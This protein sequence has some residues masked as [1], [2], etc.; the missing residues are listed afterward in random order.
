MD[1]VIN[2]QWGNGLNRRIKEYLE[3]NFIV[4][5]III[6]IIFEYLLFR[7]YVYRE[8]INKIPRNADQL[9][10]M[11][12]S[13]SI[14]ENIILRNWGA[15]LEVIN[16]EVLTGGL[17]FI[18]VINLFLFGES[19]N[20]FLLF[21]FFLYVLAQIVGSMTIYK[22]SKNKWNIL[23]FIGLFLSLK[24]PFYWAGDLLDFRQDFA[25][26]CLYTIW[27]SFLILYISTENSRYFLYSALVAGTLIFCRMLSCI[28]IV[29]NIFTLEFIYNFIF[30]KIKITEGIINIIKYGLF[31]I[32][33]GGWFLLLRI[34]NFL[35]YYINLHV[36]NDEP[37]IRAVE[38]KVYNWQDNILFYPK[39]MIKDHIGIF[40]MCL[41][42]IVGG[43]GF[44][45]VKKKL[46]VIQKIIL[47]EC[48]ISILIP[49]IILTIDVSKSSVV[50]N[51]VS[52]AVVS[53]IALLWIV[54]DEK[55][56]KLRKKIPVIIF[57]VGITFFI[58][59]ITSCHQGYS[60]QEQRPL[61][62]INSI[63]AEY[64][65]ETENNEPRILVDHLFD[66]IKDTSVK[67][68]LYENYKKNINVLDAVDAMNPFEDGIVK[69]S[70]VAKT[71]NDEEIADA[72][73][74]AD[75]IV[76]SSEGYGES[77]YITDKE[78]DKYRDRIW[79]YANE[80]LNL[81]DTVKIDGYKVSVFGR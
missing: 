40:L 42:I 5:I 21:N 33:G 77:L 14:Y 67:Y 46:N 28:Y 39:S 27:L 35:S 3:K 17:V 8:V 65:I 4:A 22:I 61:I 32:I 70:E 1:K 44:L 6:M 7:T 45:I 75:I 62:K 38:Q 72:L 41:L 58:K 60:I 29:F 81:I 55:K 79:E 18:G 50:I 10:Y 23:L 37:A 12:A 34:P 31:V 19:Y 13:Y 26:F 73:D 9:S 53:L 47:L 24:S 66:A 49:I 68:W 2:Q 36:M 71:F 80:K 25:A 43:Y 63:I 54:V 56:V 74:K 59:N 16:S 52:G 20:S 48:I 64:I 69:V 11:T 30:K 51:I 76:V 57:L 15:V 78:Y